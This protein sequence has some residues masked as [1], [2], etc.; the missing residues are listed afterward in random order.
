[1]AGG[2]LK[3][4]FGLPQTVSFAFV[5]GAQMAHLT[6][7]G[8]ARHRLLKRAGWDVE[9]RGY[10]GA[11]AIRIVTSSERH[12]SIERAISIL[13]FRKRAV[14]ALPCN[15]QGQLEPSAM[16]RALESG[17]RQ[18]TIVLLQAGDLNIGAFDRFADLIPI[19]VTNGSIRP[20]TAGTRS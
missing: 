10:A 20:S 11:P 7:L 14:T 18:P 3:E 4:L 6:C 15:D 13:G 8:A 19:T 2:W 5:T 1:M 16:K 9:E 17:G 12:G